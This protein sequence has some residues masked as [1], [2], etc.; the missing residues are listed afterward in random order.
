MFSSG[1]LACF[2]FIKSLAKDYDH[3]LLDELCDSALFEGANYTTKSV[4][5]FKHLDV[6]DMEE[7]LKVLRQTKDNGILVVTD[8][9]FNQDSSSPDLKAYQRITSENQAYLLLNLGHDFCAMGPNGRGVWEEQGLT[10]LQNVFF[11]GSGS[12]TLGVNFGFIALPGAKGNVT[13]FWKYFCSTYMFTNAINPI[14]CNS[15][16]ATLRMAR[17]ELGRQLRGQVLSNST[18]LR[19][20]IAAKGLQPL[21]RASP[22]V[23]VK[24]GS[25]VLARIILRIMMENG[26]FVTLIEFPQIKRGEAVIRMSLTPEHTHEQ[27]DRL[28]DVL[29]QSVEA[30]NVVFNR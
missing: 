6:N 22:F 26:V 25:D 19:E 17:S 23:C 1:W 4:H 27:I 5:T 7:K 15:G 18:Y 2:G 3:V 11:L 16:L 10:D 13:H 24:V 28:V 9:L 8:S 30:G 20:K 14:Q 12:K 21:G 29:V